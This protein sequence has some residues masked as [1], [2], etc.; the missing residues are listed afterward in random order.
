MYFEKFMVRVLRLR[1][2][3]VFAAILLLVAT[4]WY[5]S[6]FMKFSLFA[7]NRGVESIDIT[8][9]MPI[10]TSLDATLA[11]IIEAEK[12]I[13]NFPK[14]EVVSFYSRVGSGGFRS[15]S[16]THLATISMFMV[17]DSQLTRTVENITNDLRRRLAT[18]K[19]V[20]ALNVGRTARGM[21]SGRPIEVMV[22][23]AKGGK[24]YPGHK[25]D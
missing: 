9:E 15:A 5:A 14:S 18:V 17:P 19:D 20:K 4:G 24:A 23:G 10:G 2:A 25:C 3:W 12:I 21:K 7:R 22:K 1:Y 16:G 11:K 8:L 13:D 6:K